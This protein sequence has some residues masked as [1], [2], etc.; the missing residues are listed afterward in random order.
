MKKAA[1]LVA[2][3]VVIVIAALYASKSNAGPTIALGSTF[4]KSQLT[5]AEFGY[6]YRDWEVTIGQIG[7]G[8][9]DY[10]HQEVVDV[11]SLSKLIR[12]NWCLGEFCNYYR[13]GISKIDESPLVGETNFRLGIGIEH[14]HVQLEFGHDSSAG[15]WENNGGI[16]ALFLRLKL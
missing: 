2:A 11:Y 6:E 16:D 4:N 15:V 5:Y 3:F 12:P 14:K 8:Q 1:Y 7:E 13:I 10:G 9:T